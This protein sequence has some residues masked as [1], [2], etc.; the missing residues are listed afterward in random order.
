VTSQNRE[1]GKSQAI[2]KHIGI[3]LAALLKGHEADPIG[4]F[5]THQQNFIARAW[6]RANDKAREPDRVG[7][8]VTRLDGG[9]RGQ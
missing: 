6:K 8:D 3:K 2:R 9:L 4:P 5:P 7:T 1:R